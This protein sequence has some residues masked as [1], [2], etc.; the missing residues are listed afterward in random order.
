M[1]ERRAEM[2][3]IVVHR[4]NARGREDLREGPLHHISVLK[5]VRDAR[6]TAEV[7]LEHVNL[8]VGVPEQ[9]GS[10]D[11]APDAARWI[12]RGTE[13]ATTWRSPARAEITPSFKIRRS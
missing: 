8:A 6:W 13:P 2:A 9:I 10:G 12:Q 4:P 7:V 5:D 3:R 11:M 1:L